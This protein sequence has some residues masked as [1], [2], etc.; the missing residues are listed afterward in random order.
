MGITISNQFT[1]LSDERDRTN[2]NLQVIK[3]KENDKTQIN[4]Y[5]NQVSIYL[6]DSVIQQIA[7]SN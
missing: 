1:Y 6:S 5:R 3:T 2:N 4:H 7:V